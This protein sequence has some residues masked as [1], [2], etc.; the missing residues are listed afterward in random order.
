M[1]N[2]KGKGSDSFNKQNS[3][4]F[5]RVTSRTS[6]DDDCLL[7]QLADYQKGGDLIRYFTKEGPR[8]TEELLK[9]Q[10]PMLLYRK[11]EGQMVRR[12]DYLKWKYRKKR[13]M[14]VA[15]NEDVPGWADHFACWNF[16]YRGSLGESLLHVLIVCNTS[17]HT[18]LAKLLIVLFPNLA[19]DVVEG[20]EFRGASALHLAIAY[21]SLEVIKLLVEAGA[22]VDQRA[23]GTFFLPRDQQRERPSRVT[24]YEGLAYFG[25][26]PISWAA[27]C[28]N[29][30][31]YNLL[32]DRGA[33][34]NSQDSFGNMVLHMV[35]VCNKL[36][37][38]GYA[39]RHPRIQAKMGII[40][41]AGLTPLTLS[42]HLGRAT[43]FR[44]M[45]ELT[46]KEFWRYSN[47]TCSAYPLN[48]LDTILPDGRCNMTSAL[49]IILNGTKE[50]HL[51]MLDGGIIQ[52]L[53]EEKW[54]TFAQRQFLKR[55]GILFFH[56]FALSA[57]VYTRPRR[58]RP[59]IPHDYD[60]LNAMD[61]AR[62]CF[63]I[64]TCLSCIGYVVIQQISELKN[65][66]LRGF[67]YQLSNNP[68][69]AIFLASNFLTLSCIPCRLL[70]K[71]ELEEAILIFALPSA[72]FFLMF[73]AGA[74]RLTGP[75][76]T[77][78]YSMI[79]GDMLTFAIIYAI[80]LLAFS[81][82]F[83]F[84]HRGHPDKPPLFSNFFSTWMGLFQWTLGDYNYNSLQDTVYPALTKIVF[85]I[86]MIMVPILLLNM[87]IAMM[88]N[89]YAL[90]IQQSEK[91]WVKQWAK[92]V[93]A[94]ERAVNQ[95]HC[96]EYLLTYSIKVS[97]GS[98]GTDGSP[99]QEEVRG[100]MVI[101]SKNKTR[102]RQRKGA[103]NNWKR[104]GKRTIKELKRRGIT[105]DQLR[106]QIWEPRTPSTTSI[107]ASPCVTPIPCPSS[108]AMLL[109]D[110]MN[111]G[112]GVA[113][114]G[115]GIDSFAFGAAF[116][117]LS[118][119][120]GG[121]GHQQNNAPN[122]APVNQDILNAALLNKL[123]MNL[124][125]EDIFESTCTAP[126]AA[127]PP[128]AAV[129]AVAPVT[130]TAVAPV[131]P[132]AVVVPDVTPTAVVAPM[133]VVLPTVAPMPVVAQ[134][135]AV[136]APAVVPV[137]TV[138]SATAMASP[139]PTNPV[140]PAPIEI[141]NP[142]LVTPTPPTPTTTSIFPPL[143]PL[144]LDCGPSFTDQLDNSS[145]LS[146]IENELIAQTLLSGNV[147]HRKTAN[148][149]PGK[150]SLPPLFRARLLDTPNQSIEGEL[151]F[152]GSTESA[153]SV[154]STP[155]N[156]T[157]PMMTPV[158]FTTESRRRS[159]PS[160]IQRAESIDVVGIRQQ[161][162]E[163][164]SPSISD[165]I[166]QPTIII[167]TEL[168]REKLPPLVVDDKLLAAVHRDPS[169]SK[170]QNKRSKHRHHRRHHQFIRSNVVA[171][172]EFFPEPETQP[173]TE[174][175]QLE[176]S[177]SESSQPD[178]A[179]EE[180]SPRSEPEQVIVETVSNPHARS[181]LARSITV[182]QEENEH[183]KRIQMLKSSSSIPVDHRVHLTDNESLASS[184]SGVEESLYTATRVKKER[185]S[186]QSSNTS[187]G[188]QTA[189][190]P[191]EQP[192]IMASDPVVVFHISGTGVTDDFTAPG[193]LP[194][195][196][197]LSTKLMMSTNNKRP[198]TRHTAKMATITAASKVKR[199]NLMTASKGRNRSPM[200]REAVEL[201]RSSTS[202][203]I[204]QAKADHF[205]PSASP[206]V[207][208]LN[209]LLS[210][211]DIESH[212][213]DEMIGDP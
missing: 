49:M 64:V 174:V 133:P 116:N 134:P 199:F 7:Y 150:D 152:A 149:H 28:N 109:M 102:A 126:V 69:K 39:L 73:F 153:I 77:M 181:L 27:C 207:L 115:P 155:A 22:I 16:D 213:P 120:S 205:S 163:P 51:D 98:D 97:G 146:D 76:V 118:G 151:I 159:S 85:V 124:P 99:P 145:Q 30:A 142:P 148:S 110:S 60:D 193:R 170:N 23:V 42:C 31:A 197:M 180:E 165:S 83:F 196:P 59:L 57:A 58:D 29:E 138:T 206:A 186:S 175:C 131:T 157:V 81:Q 56:L 158:H 107:N 46:A 209:H 127:G 184:S 135:M 9:E 108:A 168:K 4:A 67:L 192:A 61:I 177:T 137:D 62:F 79:T 190:S 1:G 162:N 24:D 164:K 63:E 72:W 91:E 189:A 80:M 10:I 14:A 71:R 13:H 139:I 2:C 169:V 87:L 48:A 111:G 187:S 161:F 90:V 154:C 86:F 156:T 122:P 191:E 78:I 65:V 18:K 172:M 40:N 47:I 160:V 144:P 34:P 104:V 194:N 93:I 55:L 101:K 201:A 11:G 54:K 147:K 166:H 182:T 183:R 128:V 195:S 143:P 123:S 132:T 20:N 66:G 43:I 202:S 198:M 53:L 12:S 82:A 88:G 36:E 32:I 136:V 119:F 26:Y 105:G 25:E 114:G 37:M 208:N 179:P 200:R 68:A 185:M 112:S 19:L 117:D 8:A 6:T 92:I 21:D 178:P 5:D 103:L 210:G 204:D 44:E 212:I 41:K 130:P 113:M 50:E 203:R 74:I 17:V 84:L 38:Y 140:P 100:V 106:R 3:S 121:G 94:L 141:S 15:V 129:T 33:D 167:N 176:D 188:S 52:R 35:V 96:K 173:T 125:F 89:T 75:F 171:P 45:L 211:D 95:M 70:G